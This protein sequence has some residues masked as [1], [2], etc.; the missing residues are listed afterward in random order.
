MRFKKK[1]RYKRNLET[2]SRNTFTNPTGEEPQLTLL[3]FQPH[4][5]NL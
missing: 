4:A 3:P 1:S 2:R 5:A